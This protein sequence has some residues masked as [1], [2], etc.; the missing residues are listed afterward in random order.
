MQYDGHMK[1]C[2]ANFMIQ[3]EGCSEDS[4]SYCCECVLFVVEY[5]VYTGFSRLVVVCSYR[6]LGGL[7]NH[8]PMEDH[9][10]KIVEVQTNA[11]KAYTDRWLIHNY[12][13]RCA[14]SWS[15]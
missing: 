3:N 7:E 14:M 13:Y 2:C 10:K 15:L 5:I 12:S 1:F 4:F 8:M 9:C 6:Q 11:Y